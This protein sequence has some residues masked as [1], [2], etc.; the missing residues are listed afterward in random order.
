V[1]RWGYPKPVT[2]VLA[3]FFKKHNK[4]WQHAAICGNTHI[5]L[6]PFSAVEQ[7]ELKHMQKLLVSQRYEVQENGQISEQNNTALFNQLCTS[8]DTAAAH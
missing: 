6:F 8:N 1:G 3:N 5:Q 2:S 4:F 7:Q